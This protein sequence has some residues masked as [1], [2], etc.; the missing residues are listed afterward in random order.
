MAGALAFKKKPAAAAGA[1][2]KAARPAKKQGAKRPKKEG[3]GGR[4]RFVLT[5]GEEGAILIFMR[6]SL[7][8]R[9]LF[10]PSPQPS[11]V[12]A[13]AELMAGNPKAPLMVLLDVLDQQ[14]VRQTFPP[15]SSLSV[16]GL[17]KRRLDRDFQAED[18]K[19]SL[20]LGRDKTG[21]KEWNFLLIALSKTPLLQAWLDLLLELPN[22]L[23]GLYLLPV[24]ATYFMGSLHKALSTQKPQE[25]QLLVSHHKVSGFR[26]VVLRGGKLVFTRVTQ[27]I[28]DAIPAVIGG[29]IEQEVINTIEY[30]RRL[31]LQ[32]NSMLESYLIVSSDVRDAL[33]MKRFNLASAHVMTPLDVAETM[34]LEQ[35]ALSA[36]RFGDVVVAATIGIAKKQMLRLSTAYADA[37]AK[38]YQLNLGLR[39]VTVLASLA[40]LAMAGMSVVSAFEAR[41][42]AEEA[43]NKRKGLQLD[44]TKQQKDVAGLNKDISFKTAV[45]AVYDSYLKNAQQPLELMQQ[46]PGV[47]N[48]RSRVVSIDWSQ[49]GAVVDK[50]AGAVSPAPTAG[51]AAKPAGPVQVKLQIAFSGDY[52]NAKELQ[53]AADELLEAMK[54]Q[55]PRYEVSHDPYPWENSTKQTQEI[56]YDTPSES[57]A[58]SLQ[59]GPVVYVL[60]GPTANKP[61]AAAPAA[62]TV[63]APAMAPAPAAMPGGARP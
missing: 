1:V 61:A 27:S 3:R 62:A 32:D 28:D 52:K 7:V 25:W 46:L 59:A 49:P 20:P 48:D 14:Y 16:G 8:V 38:L 60:S 57:E 40:L 13:M 9:R 39:A 26:Q 23:K 6:G 24:E 47:L 15:V 56:S 36:D 5:I 30:L 19:G 2:P 35:A 37:L 41:S 22:P 44:I 55:L 63:A 21:R 4:G 54:K 58:K 43:E 33:D 17:V 12:E 45:V 18:I 50:K 51:G 31:G 53:K 29:N 42:G 11:H 10:A 34:G